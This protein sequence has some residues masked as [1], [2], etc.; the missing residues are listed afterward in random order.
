MTMKRKADRLYEKALEELRKEHD[1]LGRTMGLKFLHQAL[2]ED[3]GHVPSL[4]MMGQLQYNQGHSE[5]CLSCAQR[6]LAI[7]PNDL[8]GLNLAGKGYLL[9][10][11]F[12]RARRMFLSARREDPGYIKAAHNLPLT[13]YIEGNLDRAILGWEKAL[14]IDP[15]FELTLSTL[16]EAYE[17]KGDEEHAI[18]YGERLLSINPDHFDIVRIL[19]RLYFAT[20]RYEE[21]V[22]LLRPEFERHPIQLHTSSLVGGLL[23]QGLM[24]QSPALSSIEIGLLALSYLKT[25]RSDD[26]IDLLGEVDQ[27]LQNDRSGEP[28]MARQTV[29]T[30]LQ[31]VVAAIES[32]DH[33]VLEYIYGFFPGMAD[34]RR[35]LLI[36]ADVDTFLNYVRDETVEIVRGGGIAQMRREE[37][38]VRFMVK[39]SMSEF[40]GPKANDRRFRFLEALLLDA[41]YIEYRSDTVALTEAGAQYIALP[42]REQFE[43][44][45]DTWLNT[46]RWNEL[47]EIEDFYIQREPY[48][49]Y[50]P[51][52]DAKRDLAARRRT[53]LK[54]LRDMDRDRICTFQELTEQIERRDR[55]FLR[56]RDEFDRWWVHGSLLGISAPPGTDWEDIEG[57]AIASFLMGPCVWLH[58]IV[59][60]GENE[61]TYGA[62]IVTPLIDLKAAPSAQGGGVAFRPNSEI[63]VDLERIDLFDLRELERFATFRNGCGGINVYGITEAS[64]ARAVSQGIEAERLLS[65]LERN[66]ESNVPDL[67]IRSVQTWAA[68]TVISREI[69]VLRADA[70]AVDAIVLEGKPNRYVVGHLSP[71]MLEVDGSTVRNLIAQLE[72]KIGRPRISDPALTEHVPA[73]TGRRKRTAPDRLDSEARTPFAL[74]A[75]ADAL[76]NYVRD[77]KVV[78]SPKQGLFPKK[79]IEAAVESFQVRETITRGRPTEPDFPR[80]AFLRSICTE[81]TLL[82]VEERINPRV[83]YRRERGELRMLLTEEGGRFLGAPP[84][85][86]LRRLLDIWREQI[87]WNPPSERVD[88][89]GKWIWFG[90]D[91]DGEELDRKRTVLAGLAKLDPGRE[92]SYETFREEMLSENP[93]LNKR[94]LEKMVR[95]PLSWLGMLDVRVG[96]RSAIAFRITDEGGWLLKPTESGPSYTSGTIEIEDTGEFLVPLDRVNDITLY[97]IQRCAD[98]IAAGRPPRFKI[99]SETVE[100]ARDW[101]RTTEEILGFLETLSATPLPPNLIAS[102]REWG[103][104][105]GRI[106]IRRARHLQFQNEEQRDAFEREHSEED[107]ERLSPTELLILS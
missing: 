106:E 23:A 69:T 43:Q 64:V 36:L 80:F 24:P 54:H 30:V 33:P 32:L 86:K 58:L 27:A 22:R 59:T 20:E 35:V 9:Q 96:D 88:D 18:L 42:P 2:Q 73:R 49:A 105:Y 16:V 11:R 62:F 8:E 55:Y 81:G 53:V 25:D 68:G 56:S 74:L 7:A 38:N 101:G 41:G 77:R 63:Q 94:Y 78:L 44:L 100:R 14:T 15:E 66:G 52:E 90:P 26:L 67:L 79:E 61:Q 34:T 76:L 39:E 19:S 89:P 104:R 70:P 46:R 45:F 37:L 93:T 72:K 31:S 29:E 65:V 47:F 85:E 84:E 99:T 13:D 83:Q 57:P 102:I 51:E 50:P 28:H 5:E 95:E 75:D 40:G 91:E 3:P 103:E 60:A 1:V 87:G 6:V 82:K 12:R 98:L 92:H 107:I 97:E 71:T 17:R 4:L 21:I 48:G 10:R